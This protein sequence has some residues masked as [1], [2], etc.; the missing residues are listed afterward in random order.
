MILAK[1]V[2]TWLSKTFQ[3]FPKL[4]NFLICDVYILTKFKW[5]LLYN[6]ILNFKLVPLWTNSSLGTIHKWLHSSRGKWVCTFVTLYDVGKTPFLAWQG[7]GVNLRSKLCDVFYECP[8]NGKGVRLE[9]TLSCSC[10]LLKLSS[11]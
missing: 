5:L 11:Y 7:E 8:V 4:S 1:Y 10:S 3:N 2:R 6:L 9:R